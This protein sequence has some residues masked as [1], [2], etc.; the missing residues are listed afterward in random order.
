M[1]VGDKGGEG[2]VG[3]LGS[4]LILKRLKEQELRNFAKICSERIYENG[5]FF[6]KQG[7]LGNEF[8]I[9]LEGRA[10]ITVRSPEGKDVEVGVI[11]PG[12]VFGEASIFTDLPRT[13]SA[14]A[15][16]RCR[17]AVVSRDPLFAY[18]DAN[19]KAGLKIFTF[20]I[21]SLLRRLGTTS[22]DLAH[23]RDSTMT[24]EEMA[25][26]M[27]SFPKSLEDILAG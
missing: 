8:H 26:L 5:E 15:R 17:V 23:E 10:G 16:G 9:L 20:V 14:I 18:C 7:S 27:K 22:L 19:P 3:D 12:D 4:A 1:I 6:V 11:E 13:A 21:Y 24:A 2:L 25:K